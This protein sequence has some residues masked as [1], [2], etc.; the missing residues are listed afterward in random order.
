MSSCCPTAVELTSDPG[1]DSVALLHE[2][3]GDQRHGQAANL[4][5]S[6]REISC[7]DMLFG[8]QRCAATAALCGLIILHKK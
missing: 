2:V 7:S 6:F 5:V 1:K 8:A 4:L 3:D